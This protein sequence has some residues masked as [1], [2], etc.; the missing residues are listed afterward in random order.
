[1]TPLGSVRKR[2][3]GIDPPWARFDGPAGTLVVDTAIEAMAEWQR[4]GN[5]A[6]TGGAF[7]MAHACEELVD[8]TRARLG[9]LFG[10]G[11]ESIVLG[12]S[13]TALIARLVTAIAPNLGEGDEIVCTQLDH[14]A[15]VAPW[16]LL[17]RERGLTIRTA[18]LDPMNGRLDIAAIA[19]ELSS[20]TR[21]V[22]VTGASNVLGTVPDLVGI[23]ELAHE[24]GARV[25]VDG[26]HLTP[27]QP[28]DL[29][30]IGCDAYVTSAYKWF[31]PHGSAMSVDP[32]L[33]ADLELLRMR[34]G[35]E[36][37]PSRFEVGTAP[38]EI[39]AG[40]EAAATYL[41]ET[42]MD[43]IAAHEAAL[44]E[45][46]LE[47]LLSIRGVVVHG[48]TSLESRTPTVSFS[49]AGHHPGHVAEALARR[50]IAVWS[51]HNY[52]VGAVEALGLLQTG[53]VVR[54]G[55]SPYSTAEDVARLL[56]AVT[57]LT[58]ASNDP[59]L[60]VRSPGQHETEVVVTDPPV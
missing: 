46:L 34:G 19:A 30:T 57:E 8:A 50:S 55:I 26:V 47:G 59:A 23:T 35:P 45:P 11:S 10:A 39:L 41:L 18:S 44:F 14:E 29:S 15:N 6:N 5:T 20:R 22:A 49:I 25:M 52:G 2:F 32:A 54:A 56:E 43:R 1:M 60:A 7:A 17:A 40:M 58:R 13:A 31:G 28:V 33:L 4:S 16:R 12:P 21:W 48:P 36:S 27:H 9:L 38:F 53:G 51:G 37:G 24:A 42:G 3:P